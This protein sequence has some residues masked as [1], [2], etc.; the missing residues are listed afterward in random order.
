ML[1]QITHQNTASPMSSVVPE[2][3]A[4]EQVSQ[5]PADQPVVMLNLLKFR[6]R[7]EEGKSGKRL[8]L[9]YQKRMVPV[10]Q[11]AGGEA[12]WLGQAKVPLVTDTEWDMTVLV[13]YPN[14]KA[15]VDMVTSKEYAE[16][17]HL[18]EQA[19]EKAVLIAHHQM[20]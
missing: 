11:K 15:F 17:S 20:G 2:R 4:I 19:L 3:D 14:P 9:L 16:V 5:L 1:L 18:R 6:D 7:T 8:Y 12:L 10:L 13:K